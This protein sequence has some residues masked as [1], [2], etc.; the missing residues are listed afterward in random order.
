MTYRDYIPVTE[1]ELDKNGN[2]IF[3][4]RRDIKM[5]PPF[6]LAFLV[7]I[8]VSAINTRDAC[9][10][11]LLFLSG[12]RIKEVLELR[13]KDLIISEEDL[14]FYTFN[15]KTFRSKQSGDYS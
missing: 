3:G 11:A 9:L 1:H 6:S 13:K 4:K 14:G 12:R 10:I 15:E 7:E 8:C 5:S 2:D